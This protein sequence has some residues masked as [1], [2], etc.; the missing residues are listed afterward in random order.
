MNNTPR[1]FV[2]F[3]DLLLLGLGVFGILHQEL[4]GQ[5]EPALLVVYTTLLGIPGAANVLSI[6]KSTTVAGASSS[7]RPPES[8]PPSGPSQ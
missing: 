7:S 3:R 5:P 1:W 8:Q 2:V 6:L 4:T